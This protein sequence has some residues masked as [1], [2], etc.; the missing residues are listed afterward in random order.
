VVEY[1]ES[2]PIKRRKGG[3]NQNLK[4]QRSELELHFL[5]REMGR[6]SSNGKSKGNWGYGSVYESGG[7]KRGLAWDIKGRRPHG[8]GNLKGSRLGGKLGSHKGVEPYFRR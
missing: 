3:R 2:G 7:G 1:C 4:R 5:R 8:K 6:R